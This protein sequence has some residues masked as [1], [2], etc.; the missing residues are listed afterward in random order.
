[1]TFTVTRSGGTPAE[2]VF[3]STTTAEGFANSN[4]FIAL[5]DQAIAFAAG[6]LT[7]TVTVSITNDT[8]VEGTE[9]FGLVVQRNTTDPD[10]TFLTKSTFTVLDNDSSGPDT[11]APLFVSSSPLDNASGIAIN[12]NI[13]LTFNEAVKAGTGNFKLIN[14]ANGTFVNIAVTDTSQVSFSGNTVTINPTADLLINTSYELRINAAGTIKDIAGNNFA[15]LTNPVNFVTGTGTVVATTYSLSPAT[16]IIDEG[17]GTVTFTV[18]RSGDTPA[19][20]VFASTTTTEGFANSGDFTALADPPL[21]L[22]LAAFPMS[23][24]FANP[25]IAF[26]ITAPNAM[27]ILDVEFPIDEYTPWFKLIVWSVAY[28]EASS[29]ST[30]PLSQI[31]KAAFT[32]VLKS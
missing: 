27:T 17:A 2:T 7:K 26:S 29:V 31:A 22:L 4:D 20:T 18:T 15:T 8:I 11:T 12:A 32:F 25:P 6:E 5:A 3:A 13:V 1:M 28:C 9:T 16:T 23:E 30:P 24:S 21:K 10:A 19:E 14:L